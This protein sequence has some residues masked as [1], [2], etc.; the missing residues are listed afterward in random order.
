MTKGMLLP[1]LS[2]LAALVFRDLK[3]RR[4]PLF[5]IGT[6]FALRTLLFFTEGGGMTALLRAMLKSLP[7]LLLTLL[8]V[9]FFDH[10]FG[11]KTAGG[12]D[13]WFIALLFFAFPFG[14]TLTGIFLGLL[15]G[16]IPIVSKR[17]RGGKAVRIPLT[18]YLLIGLEL[19]I[20]IGG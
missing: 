19:V 4:V 6:G 7:T 18:P 14:L 1:M 16:L 10:L 17:I 11:K 2:V 5:G 8:L 12:G 3:A 13:L 15:L 20:L 9:L